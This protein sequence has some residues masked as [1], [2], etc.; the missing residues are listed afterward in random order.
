MEP[1]IF[2]KAVDAAPI[3][4]IALGAVLLVIYWSLRFI[5]DCRTEDGTRIVALTDAVGKNNTI[6]A[7]LGGRM[8]EALNNSTQAIRDGSKK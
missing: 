3:L 5:K 6:I 7:E 1:E 4:A 2:K 8:V